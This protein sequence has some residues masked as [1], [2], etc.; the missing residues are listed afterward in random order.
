MP[1]PSAQ[2]RRL[3]YLEIGAAIV[4]EFDDRAASERS[5]EAL[6]NVKL[7][8]VADR[9]GVTKG[10]LYH[11]W[12]GQEEYR[13]DLLRRL[14]D[15]S[16]QAGVRELTSLLSDPGIAS[17]P[18]AGL[19]KVAD[20]VFQQLKDDRAFFARFSFFL[21]A[22]NPRVNEL[23]VSGDAAV[24]DEMDPFV[25]VYLDQIGRRI[26]EPFTTRQLL[27]SMHSYFQ[28][29]CLRYRTSPDLVDKP[30]LDD[31]DGPSMYA[32]GL[33][34]LLHHFSEPAPRADAAV[35]A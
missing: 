1:R 31:P 35:D 11:V 9:A 23:L 3:E 25:T 29:L 24:A 26:R 18:R 17:D 12:S 20:Y 28:G 2:E 14:F 34:A 6:A 16:Q 15:H 32:F 30:A 4:A 8:D 22:R 10:A 13:E 33:E 19:R 5:V 27:V 21:Y 7:A